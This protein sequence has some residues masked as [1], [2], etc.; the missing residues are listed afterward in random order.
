MEAYQREIEGSI[1]VTG[2][3]LRIGDQLYHDDVLQYYEIPYEEEKMT[4]SLSDA[5]RYYHR[6][7]ENHMIRVD[8]TEMYFETEDMEKSGYYYICLEGDRVACIM[9]DPYQ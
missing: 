1:Y 3:Q 9:W 7:D 8:E 5:I 6:F 2:L 4:V